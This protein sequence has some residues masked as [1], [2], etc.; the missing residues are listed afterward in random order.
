M[1]KARLKDLL[2]AGENLVERVL[3][4]IRRLREFLTNLVGVFLKAFLDFFLEYF[5]QCSVP[6]PFLPFCRKVGDQV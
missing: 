6:N 1:A 4:V 3:E 5:L 2:S